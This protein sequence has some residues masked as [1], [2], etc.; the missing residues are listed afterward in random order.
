MLLRLGDCSCQII[1]ELRAA[2]AIHHAMIAGK[3]ERHHAADGGLAVNRADSISNRVGCKARSTPGFSNDF[4]APMAPAPAAGQMAA[5]ASAFRLPAGLPKLTWMGSNW[6]AP[7][8]RAARLQFAYRLP[9]NACL[10][11][12]FRVNPVFIWG[13]LIYLLPIG[14]Q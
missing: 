5:R 7:T 4:S 1:Q 11:R 2:R 3:R 8:P 14:R 9:A 13:Y 10:P 6:C 12:V